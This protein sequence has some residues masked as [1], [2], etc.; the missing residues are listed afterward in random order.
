[1]ITT[2][3]N[4]GKKCGACGHAHRTLK[5]AASCISRNQ[6]KCDGLGGWSDRLT[7]HGDGSDLTDAELDAVNGYLVQLDAYSGIE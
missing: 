7:F 3:T 2:Y 5:S 6:R 1:M 4:I